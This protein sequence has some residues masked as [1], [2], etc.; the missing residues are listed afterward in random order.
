[1]TPS[2]KGKVL[3]KRP[4]TMLNVRDKVKLREEA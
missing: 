2:E 3:E 4:K 1:V